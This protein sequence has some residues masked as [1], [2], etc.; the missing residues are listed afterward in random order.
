MTLLDAET[1]Q[2]G[3]LLTGDERYLEPYTH[4][5]HS[6]DT[7]VLQLTHALASFQGAGDEGT[8]VVV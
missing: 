7:Q 8:P 4:A 5:L 3:F 6:A 2:R 1:G